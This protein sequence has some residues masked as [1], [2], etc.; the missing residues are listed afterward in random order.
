[1][2]LGEM[3]WWLGL[4]PWF[5]QYYKFQVLCVWS[6]NTLEFQWFFQNTFVFSVANRLCIAL[7]VTN[8]KSQ[9]VKNFFALGFHVKL[10]KKNTTTTCNAIMDIYDYNN[11]TF[12]TSYGYPYLN[13]HMCMES[14]KG[15]KPLLRV[16]ME[17]H[18]A[19]FLS[20]IQLWMVSI[21]VCIMSSDN[22]NCIHDYLSGRHWQF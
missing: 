8:T 1:M 20:I 5:F 13:C 2:H 10:Y 3:Q 22:H 6:W 16:L 7:W 15:V 12:H 14:P 17:L 4:T 18:I 11:L 19:F 9:K 21:I